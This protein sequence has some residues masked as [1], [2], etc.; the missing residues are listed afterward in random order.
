MCRAPPQVRR[1]PRLRQGRQDPLGARI[2]VP[3]FGSDVVAATQEALAREGVATITANSV[4]Q[5]A[6]GGPLTALTGEASPLVL[7]DEQVRA[8]AL[9]AWSGAG[10]QGS[11]LDAQVS[12][13]QGSPPPSIVLAAYVDLGYDPDA[14]PGERLAASLVGEVDG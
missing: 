9:D 7:I 13:P 3:S 5:G 11:A 1:S 12:V 14:T 6:P 8:I 2:K 10:I 4:G